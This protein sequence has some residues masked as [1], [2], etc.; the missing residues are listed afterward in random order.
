[1]LFQP[2][3][4]R[5]SSKLKQVKLFRLFSEQY[6]YL[7]TIEKKNNPMSPKMGK[8]FFVYIFLPAIFSGGKNCP[9]GWNSRSGEADG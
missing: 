9:E 8:F 2:Q 4:F 6:F 3:L 5:E 7:V 1:M